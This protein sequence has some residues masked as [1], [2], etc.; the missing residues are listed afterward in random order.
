MFTRFKDFDKFLNDS[1]LVVS[2]RHT[3]GTV[4]NC[5]E[6]AIINKVV[7]FNEIKKQLRIS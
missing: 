5:D 1:R 3:S 2:V 4:G 7:D 6:V